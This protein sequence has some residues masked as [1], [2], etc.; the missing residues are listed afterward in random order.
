MQR[1]GVISMDRR[2]LITH[3][4]IAGVLAAGMAP[5]VHAQTAV[6]W[7]LASSF[8]KSLDTIFGAAEVFADNV[9][10]MSGGRFEIS[11]HPAGELMP[12]L[13]VVD[14][15]Q[16]GSVEC[17]HT[18]SYY[19]FG[20]DDT[21]ALDCAIPFGLNSRQM[22][23]WLF[24]GNGMK[25]MREFFA[26]YNIIN[27]PCGNTGAQMGGW[28]RKEIKNLEDLKGLKMRIAGFAGKVLSRMGGVPQNIPAGEIYQALEKGTIDATE[29]V[30][31]YD[32]EKLGFQ[33][34][35]KNYY[36]PGWWEGSA[37]ISLYVN[38]TAYNSLSNENKAIIEC[39]SAR[40]HIEMQARYDH[41]NPAAL[42]RLAAAKVN[43]L[44]FPKPVMDEAFKVSMA[45]Y[46]ELSSTNPKWKKIYEDYSNFRKDQ[47]FWFRFTESTFDRYMQ[48]SK[49]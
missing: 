38:S 29:W 45:L 9:K 11:V 42:K 17:A 15:V 24:E 13:G 37:Q 1:T 19:F 4:G 12:A 40:A 10:K 22:T 36:Y 49:L 31:P 16:Q 46:D 39:A 18:A 21:F 14:G 5:A 34:V 6:R 25:L 23:A 47:N 27:F 32:D 8:P 2:S 48:A 28:Y 20:K 26:N 33:K 43:I 35:A 3:T 30:G 7:R 44:P 41:H